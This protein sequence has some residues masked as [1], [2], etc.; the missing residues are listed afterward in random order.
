M[1]LT[2]PG[3]MGGEETAKKLLAKYPDAVL[4]VSSGYSENPVMTNPKEY[5]FKGA[6]KKPY[7]LRKLSHLLHELLQ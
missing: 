1:D 2:I 4:L 3:G 7:D 6:L 5:G